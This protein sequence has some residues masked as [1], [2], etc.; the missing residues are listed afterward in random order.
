MAE[1]DNIYG[2]FGDIY[3]GIGKVLPFL[4]DTLPKYGVAS[5]TNILG[6]GT[7][8]LGILAENIG[9]DNLARLLRS[10]AQ[11]L[12]NLGGEFLRG[13]NI[14]ETAER[15]DREKRLN[16]FERSLA[17]SKLV[18]PDRMMSFEPPDPESDLGK[19]LSEIDS[20]LS[21][22]SPR[23]PPEGRPP[24]PT[25]EKASAEESLLKE[26]QQSAQAEE[27]L[28]GKEKEDFRAKEAARLQGTPP[29]PENKEQIEEDAF[30]MIM[31]ENLRL[32]GK[33]AKDTKGGSGARDLDFY[34]KEFAKATGVDISGKPDKSNFLMAL[35]LGL[36]QNRAGKGFNVGKILGAVGESAEKAMPKLIAAQKEA[37]ANMV[38]AG[39]YA[40]Q[41]QAKDRATA[42]SAAKNLNKKKDFFVV[43][44]GGK[45]GL[46]VN[47]YLK[48]AD[49]AR[50]MTFTNAE[51][52][53]LEN[54]PQFNNNYALLPSENYYDIL[55]ESIS[56]DE[57]KDKYR[58]TPTKVK[59]FKNAEDGSMFEVNVA[60]IN[61][62]NPD[63]TGK[64]PVLLQNA[65]EVYG[66]FARMYKDNQKMKDKFVELGILT[67]DN[68]NVFTYSLDKINSL[69]AA[70][71]I[72]FDE[73]ETESD[74]IIRIL[75]NL[76]MKKAPDIL[77]ESGKT[78]SDADRERVERI[79]G[80]L[81][82]FGDI[83]TQRARIQ[84]LFND[85]VLGAE[86]DIIE[87]IT[88]LDRYANRNVAKTLFGTDSG[89]LVGSDK[90]DLLRLQKKFG[91]I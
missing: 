5:G 14:F 65:D 51:L 25:E 83:R 18:D 47:D 77:G 89:D 75:E 68:R 88:N 74:K 55:K 44:T 35:G 2:G 28:F 79:V 86:S 67:Q 1:K 54:D 12:Y 34:K 11:D 81:K 8:V 4:I 70:F 32:A 23:V 46:T 31:E 80:Q 48:N 78:I 16:T 39:K 38:A 59:L 20:L 27:Q 50:L 45:R 57:G 9:Q 73:E 21:S 76:A 85:I 19:R 13:D 7:D 40:M 42:A 71:G 84:D 63:M 22:A 3:G 66:A 62:N 24:T 43:P 72:K 6:G 82:A 17:E 26:A 49:N 33:G 37:K 60:M 87:G 41:A 91:L 56:T 36:M 61:P 58:E 69:G 53:Q 52:A 29:T 30:K 64:N 10:N 90:E 15:L